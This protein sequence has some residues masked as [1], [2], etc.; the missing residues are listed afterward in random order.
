MKKSLF[1][2][3]DNMGFE[4]ELINK[5]ISRLEKLDD[6]GNKNVNLH[7]KR[8]KLSKKKDKFYKEKIGWSDESSD[9]FIKFKIDGINESGGRTFTFKKKHIRLWATCKKFPHHGHGIFEKYSTVVKKLPNGDEVWKCGTCASFH[10]R[11]HEIFEFDSVPGKEVKSYY[12]LEV[13]TKKDIYKKL[14]L[15]KKTSD[16]IRIALSEYK[17]GLLEKFFV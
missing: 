6:Y 7:A 17:P 4:L 16:Y 9:S 8:D 5:Q 14:K 13:S 1:E 10:N 11:G 12:I 2:Q 15:M 3:Y